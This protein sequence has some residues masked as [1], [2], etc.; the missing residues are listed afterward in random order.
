MDGR[1]GATLPWRPLIPAAVLAL[2]QSL[3]RFL[4]MAGLV[5]SSALAFSLSARA[6]IY[7]SID[8]RGVSTFTN[9]RQADKRFELFMRE[10]KPV[11]APAARFG[12]RAAGLPNLSVARSRYSNEV[13]LAARAA[14]IEPALLHAVISAE[15]GYNPLARSNKGALGMMQLMPQTAL[16][17]RVANPFDA[18]QN[19]HGGA[20]YLRD[21]LQMFNNDLRL[22]I[23]AYNAGEN[24]VVKYGNRIPPYPETIA[25]VPRVMQFYQRYS[26]APKS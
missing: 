10:A 14:E 11:A 23:A 16:R 17:Y 6:D 13:E 8:E 26:A 5:A 22:A 18:G 20:R 12:P 21:L 4:P 9:I 2:K 1:V 7:R 19:I 24:A 15:S 3:K 25:Y